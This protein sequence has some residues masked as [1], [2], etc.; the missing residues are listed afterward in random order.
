MVPLF[1]LD[2]GQSVGSFQSEYRAS[3]SSAF[4][5]AGSAG[6]TVGKDASRRGYS[7]S[8]IFTVCFSQSM[9]RR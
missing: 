3:C 2:T 9:R 6:S 7:F 8:P 1:L 5:A 4:S